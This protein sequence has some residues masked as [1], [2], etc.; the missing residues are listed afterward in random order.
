MKKTIAKYIMLL[1]SIIGLYHLA[2]FSFIKYPSTTIEEKMYSAPITEEEVAAFL[3]VWRKFR[4]KYNNVIGASEVSF[5]DKNTTD[6]MPVKI[7]FWLK[8]KN[9]EPNRFFFIEQR[10]YD[11]A[12]RIYLQKHSKDVVDLLQKSLEKEQS[13]SSKENI[14]NIIKTQENVL[15]LKTINPDE[16]AIV[17]KHYT[18]IMAILQS[19]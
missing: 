13:A 18:E 16:L 6:V 2:T 1:L 15:S 12:H 10:I 8:K 4:K 17:Q 14:K 19:D 5:S 7:S 9:F 3:P 11:I